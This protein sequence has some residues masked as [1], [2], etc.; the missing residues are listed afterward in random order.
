MELFFESIR[1]INKAKP[2]FWKLHADRIRETLSFLNL[3]LKV[4][5]D[6]LVVQIMELAKQNEIEQGGRARIICWRAGVGKYSPVSS[7]PSI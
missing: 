5:N 6:E 4:S 7:K 2:V 3:D 1:L